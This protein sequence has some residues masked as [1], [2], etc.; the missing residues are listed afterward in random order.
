MS[1]DIRAKWKITQCLENKQTRKRV[2]LKNIIGNIIFCHLSVGYTEFGLNMEYIFL[3]QL[4][5]AN[6]L[7]T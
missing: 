5:R 6:L 1:T 2:T 3:S 4:V 7:V